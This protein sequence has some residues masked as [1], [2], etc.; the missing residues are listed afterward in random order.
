[1]KRTFAAITAFAAIALVIACG[2]PA[3]PPESVD[4]AYDSLKDKFGEAQ[5]AEEKA[6]IAEDFLARFP[7]SEYTGGVAG[8]IVYYRG[9]ELGEPQKAWDSVQAALAKVEDPEIRFETNMNLLDLS[10]EIGQPIDLAAVAAELAEHR[11]LTY[12]EHSDIMDAGIN[13][14]LWPVVEVHAA[15]GL[16]LA[17]AEA[18]LADYPDDEYT[19]EEATEKAGRR[20]AMSMTN[21]AWA[22]ANTDRQEEAVT[23]FETIAALG[24]TN[25]LGVPNTDVNV[26]W[27]KTVLGLGNAEQALE[28]LAPNAI[29]GDSDTAFAALKE[30]W[31]AK[32]DNDEGFDAYVASTRISLAKSIDTFTL[33]DY[34]G[35]DIDFASFNGKVTLLSFWFPT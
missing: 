4:E 22:L 34:E 15:K 2:S 30:A 31:V 17:T 25:Y 27:G 14:E 1:M 32:N 23:I 35:N 12:S 9:D 8:A 21:Q 20:K 3:L 19:I 24:S 16:E 26:Y 13:N 29:M 18:F 11:D 6:A 7:N 10:S 5:T 33:T 28:L